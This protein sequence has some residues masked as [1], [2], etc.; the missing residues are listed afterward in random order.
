MD[1]VVL[2]TGGSRGIGAAIAQQAAE[3]GWSVALNYNASPAQADAVAA[4][5]RSKGGRVETIQADMGSPEDISRLFETVDSAFGRLDAL[6]NNAGIIGAMK[7]VEEQ[8]AE[9]LAR[10]WAVNLTGC[11][12][13]AGEAVRRMSTKH[14]GAGGTIVNVSSIASRTGGMPGMTPYAATKGGMDAFTLGLAREV[15]REG[16]RVVSVRPGLIDTDIHDIYGKGDAFTAAADAVPFGGR[17][18]TAEEVANVV[19]WLLSDSASYVS[20]TTIDVSAGR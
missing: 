11:I 9:D 7:R 8:T 4:M 18:G 1:K 3:A 5:I 19:L 15:G 2:V 17:A 20:A 13:A 6:V 14:G 12:L 10:T 16:I